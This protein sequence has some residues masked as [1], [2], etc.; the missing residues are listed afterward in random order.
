M[1]ATEAQKQSEQELALLKIEHTVL[2]QDM[3][4]LLYVLSQIL[5]ILGLE[6]KDLRDFDDD[7]FK[8]T[9]KTSDCRARQA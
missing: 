9:I 2:V 6:M 1:E 7:T 3:D 8:K 4:D 5:G